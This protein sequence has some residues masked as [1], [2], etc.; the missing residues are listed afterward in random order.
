[1]QKGYPLHSFIGTSSQAQGDLAYAVNDGISRHLLVS[2]AR[3]TSCQAN[4]PIV[5]KLDLTVLEVWDTLQS[6]YQV[7]KRARYTFAISCVDDL[8]SL[9]TSDFVMVL[10]H[11]LASHGLSVR[12]L[13]DKHHTFQSAERSILDLQ[14]ETEV[15]EYLRSMIVT[16]QYQ[17]PRTPLLYLSQQ[18]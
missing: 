9:S 6:N 1:M 7:A 17:T 18:V 13:S 16:W 12:L 11:L 8:L 15:Q 2:E 14:S 3:V 4:K 5:P 10:R